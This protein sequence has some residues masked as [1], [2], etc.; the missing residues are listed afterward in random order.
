[1]YRPITLVLRKPDPINSSADCFQYH[2]W[3]RVWWRSIGFCVL[4][5]DWCVDNLTAWLW[6]HAFELILMCNWKTVVAKFVT[7]AILILISVLMHSTCTWKPTERHQTLPSLCVIL[8]VIYPGQ[9]WLGLV[10]ETTYH[11]RCRDGALPICWLLLSWI[12]PTLICMLFG[13]SPNIFLHF[14]CIIYGIACCYL[15]EQVMCFNWAMTSQAY[16]CRL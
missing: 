3:G 15:E 7:H 8:K 10:C 1:M 6:S 13:I 14:S 5:C 9:G 16:P 2:A 12:I 11:F 4:R